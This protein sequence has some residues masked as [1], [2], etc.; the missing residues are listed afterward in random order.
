MK[1]QNVNFQMKAIKQFFPM[2]LFTLEYKVVLTFDSVDETLTC[3]KL[4]ES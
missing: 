2:A 3:E 4:K 1:S